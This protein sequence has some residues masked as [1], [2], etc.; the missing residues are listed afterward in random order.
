[1][2]KTVCAVTAVAILVLGVSSPASA[3]EGGGRSPSEA[4]TIAI[5]QHYTGKLNNH[6][7]D[8]NYGGYKEVAFW[9]L[10]PVSTRDVVTVDWHSVPYT[11]DP[12]HYPLCMTLAQGIDDFNWGSVFEKRDECDTDGPF[13]ELSGSGTAHTQITVQ[14]TTTNSSYL[15]FYVPADETEPSDLET[16][17]YDFTVQPILH[18]LGLAFQPVEKVAANGVVQATATL[19]NGQPAPNG[20][21]FGLT[22]TWREG[23]I[24]AF[25]GTSS[26]GVVSF[27]LN[28]PESAYGKGA[29]FVAF[30]P[31]DGNYQEVVAPTQTVRISR[32]VAPPPSACELAQ[33][34]ALVLSRQY[35]RLRHNA[36]RARGF[37]KRRLS[38]RARR[39]K[40]R[41][42]AA[43]REVA[44]LCA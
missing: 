41:L 2:R 22:V 8:S 43:R 32:P 28:L 15:E 42:G 39:A 4:P 29:R 16:Y 13:Y 12:G 34:R 40:R 14:E 37:A 26:G 36:R 30:H 23:G 38:H 6:E 11:E 19:A 33:R 10:P 7:D 25:T 27:Q 21:T 18:Y 17:P 20:L 24:A 1:M 44:A 9:R 35:R 5:G 31:A 3:F